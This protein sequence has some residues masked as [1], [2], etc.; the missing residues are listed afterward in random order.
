MDLDN[1]KVTLDPTEDIKAT[2]NTGSIQYGQLQV[3][4][5][6][7]GEAG[8]AAAVTNSGSSSNAIL[9]FTIPKGEK[10]DAF[11][12]EDFT[13]EQLAD[14]KGDKGDKGDPGSVKFIIANELPTEGIDESAIYMIPSG[15]TEGNTYQEYIYVNGVWE[16][17]GSASVNVDLEDYVKNTDYATANK[18][19]VVKV[20]TSMGLKMNADGS[21]YYLNANA[22][23]TQAKETT[24]R[25]L[26]PKYVDYIVKY[27]LIDNQLNWTEEE[28]ATA[29]EFLGVTGL[30]EFDMS[31]ILPNYWD[32]E[33]LTTDG[34]YTYEFTEDDL[35]YMGK[36]AEMCNTPLCGLR[37]YKDVDG[38]DRWF[39]GIKTMA[40]TLENMLYFD[41]DGATVSLEEGMAYMETDPTNLSG[42]MGGY[43]N[44]FQATDFKFINGEYKP[45]MLCMQII[46]LSP[47]EQG[48]DLE[49][50][51][52][53][54]I[55]V[56][57]LGI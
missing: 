51:T 22:A 43:I 19:G 23:E 10:G 3:G 14:L 1:I 32:I 34:E 11:T 56:K 9:N 36:L 45:F 40:S 50:M 48:F 46:P 44:T 2:L 25:V 20:S 16:S 57:N 21:V 13:P 38:M 5:T 52:K 17:L 4:T 49:Y 30:K 26:T 37:Y 33:D 54:K 55:I 35:Y 8:E 39:R 7:T 42:C 24:K 47:I 28:K 6:T 12:Y 29:R 41:Y 53:V 18:A 27:G 31:D 15:E